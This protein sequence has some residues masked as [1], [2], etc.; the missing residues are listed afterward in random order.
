MTSIKALRNLLLP[1][2]L[3]LSGPIALAAETHET[4]P[5]YNDDLQ[6]VEE[7]RH[8]AIFAQPNVD[9]A[10]YDSILLESATVAFRKNWMRDQNRNRRSLSERVST[11][12]M[13]RIK[14][15]LAEL[16]DEV[17][18]DELSQD[19]A[20]KLVD[21][22]GPRVLRIRPQIVDLDVYA[23][24][25]RSSSNQRSY[26]D[27]SGRMTLKLE[28]YDAETGDLIAA[29]SDRRESPYRGYMQWTTSVS[30]KGDARQIL[31]EWAGALNERLKSATQSRQPD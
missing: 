23:P 28:L 10:S 4:D 3:L 25:V 19:G 17:F 16:F 29:A 14:T 31:K 20:W 30:N 5:G 21:A 18:V 2:A 15:D 9:W 8:G 7:D 13:E 22:A 11:S 1:V 26:T 12:D 24:A 27:S 6:L